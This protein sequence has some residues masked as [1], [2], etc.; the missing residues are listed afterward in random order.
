VHGNSSQQ[1]RSDVG[2]LISLHCGHNG[3][4]TAQELRSVVSWID[5]HTPAIVT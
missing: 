2:E 5:N 4:L 3:W 1:T